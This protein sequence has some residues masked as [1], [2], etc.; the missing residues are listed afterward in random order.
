MSDVVLAPMRDRLPANTRKMLECADSGIPHHVRMGSGP[1]LALKR[2]R[3]NHV[4]LG[5][6][7]VISQW[8]T[9]APKCVRPPE[10]MR[11]EIAYARKTQEL[12]G[13]VPQTHQTD[14]PSL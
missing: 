10:Y 6:G 9:I 5:Y 1:L 13:L 7:M 12:L 2:I 3:Y 8:M 14:R 11:A 4:A